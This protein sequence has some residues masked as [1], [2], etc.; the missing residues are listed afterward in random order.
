MSYALNKTDGS[1]LLTLV[2]GTIDSSTTDL[3]FIGKNYQGFGEILNENFIKLL[4]NFA[5]TSAPSKPVE[6]QLWYDKGAGRLKVYDGSTFRNTDNIVLGA[7]NP[8][9]KVDGDIWIDSNTKRLYFYD[10][11]DWQLIGPH[12]DYSQGINGWVT[13]TLKDK[14]GQNKIV[15]DLF[16]GG[17]RVAIYAKETF[18]PQIPITGFTTIK[19]G[20]NVSTAFSDWKFHGQAES[21]LQIVDSL[22]NV[23]TVDN[24]VSTAGDTMN[25]QLSISHPVPLVIGDTLDHKFTVGSSST[26]VQNVRD[27]ADY[28]V[29]LKSSAD[30]DAI[31]IKATEKRIGIQNSNPQAELHIGD[32]TPGLGNVIVEGDL[33]VRG[34]T[35]TL[36]VNNLRVNDKQIQLAMSEDSTVP[37]R[38]V[39]D[40]AGIVIESSEGSIDWT[41]MNATSAWTTSEN[42]EIDDNAKAYRIG[43][44]DVLS[45]TELGSTVVNS[46]LRT[47]GNLDSLNVVG[48]IS[49]GGN[50][51]QAGPLN[52]NT[53]GVVTFSNVQLRGLSN[54]SQTNDAATKGYVDNE[55]QA[56]PIILS[57][58]ITGLDYSTTVNLGSADQVWQLLNALIDPAD[59]ANGTVVKL[60][61]TV[62]DEYLV[63]TTTNPYPGTGELYDANPDNIMGNVNITNVPVDAGGTQN[64]SVVE[65]FSITD[66]YVYTTPSVSRVIIEFERAEVL[67][68]PTWTWQSTTPWSPT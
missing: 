51:I 50:I 17:S 5:N 43:N 52:I 45:K 54:P 56:F 19:S 66:P 44:S 24:F 35:T 41:W 39:L 2:D 57:V 11:S 3:I 15:N 67:S 55:L 42:I 1:L 46:S 38:S 6:G 60:I 20:I 49:L 4:E 62:A 34:I 27:G 59:K 13:R 28:I 26:V 61:G 48:N 14:N 64:Q 68:V 32:G 7:Q 25:G 53:G 40:D 36:D 47:V 9:D 33:T 29:R 18:I 21:A 63:G 37:D 8:I 31:T 10:G 16:I 22:G 12:Y 23:Y 65:S 30:Y 58:D